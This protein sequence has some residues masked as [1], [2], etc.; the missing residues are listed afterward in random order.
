MT[1]IKILLNLYLLHGQNLFDWTG[2]KNWRW[3]WEKQKENEEN[4]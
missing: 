3:T 1:G 4:A 2:P